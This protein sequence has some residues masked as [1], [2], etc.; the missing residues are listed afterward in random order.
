MKTKLFLVLITSL[1]LPS[2][3]YSAT[4]YVATKGNN[5]WSGSLENPWQTI[6]HAAETMV[7]GDI[8]YIRG[9]TYNEHVYTEQ[10]G[11]AS[12]YIVFSAYE[13]ETPIIDGTG[14]TDSQNGFII[15]KSYIKLIGLEICNWNDN[16]IWMENAAY[17]NIS[18]C[19]VHDVVYGI[20]AAEGTHDFVLNRVVMHHFDLYGF[21]ASPS[22][23]ADCYNG[24]F[25]DCIAY[26]GRDRDQNVDGFAI[27]H[28][29]QHDFTFNR[30]EAYDVYDGF[31]VGENSG[32][33]NTN[34]V[35]KSCLGHDCW[36]DGYKF[37]GSGMLVNCLS[38]G[39]D[40]SNVGFY[41]GENVGTVTLNNCTFVDAKTFNVW[42]ENSKES[43]QMYNCIL[44]G[45]NNIGLAFEQRDASNYKG[46]YNLFH[47]NNLDRVIAV[48]YEDEFSLKQVE[49]CAWTKYSGQDKHSLITYEDDNLFTDITNYNLHLLKKS[50]AIDN[51]TSVGAPT[52]DYDGNPRPKGKNHDIGAYE[53]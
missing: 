49:S 25:N 36:N 15:N 26:T 46:D 11:N 14:V 23:G 2:M 19:V 38:Y 35:L 16:G 7:A 48:G 22:G 45:G 12:G 39:N 5:N 4:Y 41:W 9:G 42:V 3:C 24:T 30:C 47:I 33:S 52:D 28:G 32:G 40:N 1:I 10:N 34:I 13:S 51:G 44:A 43:L 53:Y 27:G 17:I 20:G 8:V 50:I 29:N 6:Q 18:D 31:D 37:T 21:D